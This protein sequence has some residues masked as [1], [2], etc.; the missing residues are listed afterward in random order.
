MPIDTT[1]FADGAFM[2][3]PLDAIFAAAVIL[4]PAFLA[5]EKAIPSFDV[6]FYA[7]TIEAA[8]QVLYSITRC[9]ATLLLIMRSRRHMIVRSSCLLDAREEAPIFTMPILALD[10]WA[11]YGARK[12]DATAAPA[13][14]RYA[15]RDDSAGSLAARARRRN[16]HSITTAD[17]CRMFIILF[18]SFYHC[19]RRRCKMPPL[20]HRRLVV[21]SIS[22]RLASTGHTSRRPCK[23]TGGIPSYEENS[24]L[25]PR[26]RGQDG[27]CSAP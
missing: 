14:K 4:P 11:C 6:S 26:K 16:G 25:R 18:I 9:A 27:C 3:M 20:H 12:F 8:M 22:A 5:R 7:M 10:A 23:T 13:S 24:T 15:E 21:A 2:Q 1:S 17:V 19:A